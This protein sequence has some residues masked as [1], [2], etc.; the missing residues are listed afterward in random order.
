MG[1]IMSRLPDV[2]MFRRPARP[3]AIT[4]IAPE[5]T[6]E[7]TEADAAKTP[8]A[9][10]LNLYRH[11]NQSENELMNDIH[12]EIAAAAEKYSIDPNLIK[13]VMKSESNFN[14]E[15]LSRAGAMGLMQL[16]PGTAASLGVS[17]PYNISQNIDGGANYLRRMLDMFGEENLAVAAYNAGPNAVKKHDGIPPFN[18]TQ[19]FVPKVMGY[20]EQYILEQYRKAAQRI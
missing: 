4:E 17:D 10:L 13:A 9:Y 18:E 3:A 5:N 1:N 6:Q 20:K 14:P 12:S 15:A 16:M 7:T 19:R 8:F 11:A 2:S